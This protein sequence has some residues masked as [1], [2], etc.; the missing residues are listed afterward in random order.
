MG[1]KFTIFFLLFFLLCIWGQI[2]S[3]SPPRCLYSEGRFNGGFF[4]LRFWGAY[5]WRGLFLELYGISIRST[6]P[7]DI[8]TFYHLNRQHLRKIVLIFVVAIWDFL[9]TEKLKSQRA[10]QIWFDV[11]SISGSQASD[12]ILPEKISCWSIKVCRIQRCKVKEFRNKGKKYTS[13]TCWRNIALAEGLLTPLCFV[14]SSLRQGKQTRHK[15]LKIKSS[16]YICKSEY[17]INGLKLMVVQ[18]SLWF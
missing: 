10:T 18:F 4:A 15:M 6:N 16:V 17:F 12:D 7:T 1:R 11:P 5:T 9:K 14:D 13:P 3:T 8:S 2:P